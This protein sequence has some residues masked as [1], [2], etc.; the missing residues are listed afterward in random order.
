MYLRSPGADPRLDIDFPA[1]R[2]QSRIKH[3]KRGIPRM[4]SR[5]FGIPSVIRTLFCM[6]L[7]A[8]V[9]AGLLEA[10]TAST[11]L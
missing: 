4:N 2:S 8:A 11:G 1:Q 5:R 6:L 9:P 7:A 10:Q 3:G